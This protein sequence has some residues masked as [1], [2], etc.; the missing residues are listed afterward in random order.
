VLKPAGAQA[1]GSAKSAF[2]AVA[3][4]C[5]AAAAGEQCDLAALIGGGALSL[6]APTMSICLV[7]PGRYS[8][9]PAGVP[10]ADALGGAEA[11]R[12]ER[13]SMG[14]LPHP[15]PRVTVQTAARRRR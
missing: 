15:T 14:A 1:L 6:V 5:R 8:Q 2:G 9:P 3:G 13:E 7:R 12:L 11:I 4:L 10:E